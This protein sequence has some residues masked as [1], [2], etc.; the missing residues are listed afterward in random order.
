MFLLKKKSVFNMASTFIS[1]FVALQS[2]SA[3]QFIYVTISDRILGILGKL[4]V[5]LL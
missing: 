1:Q 5:M 2:N 3:D 4:V